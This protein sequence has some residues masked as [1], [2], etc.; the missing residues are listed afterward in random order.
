MLKYYLEVKLYNIFH[1]G[2]AFVNESL[3]IQNFDPV[4]FNYIGDI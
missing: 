1:F 2:F 3:K 4:A